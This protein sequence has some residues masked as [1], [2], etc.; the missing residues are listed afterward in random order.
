MTTGNPMVLLVDDDEFHLDMIYAQLLAIGYE[1]VVCAAS[2]AQ[3]LA[4]L[5]TW[6][7]AIGTVIC[8][9]SMP[10]MD[11]LVLIRHLAQRHLSAGIILLSGAQGE[12]L[13]SAARLV[14]AHKMNLLGVLAKPCSNAQLQQLLS[15][16]QPTSAPSRP[17]LAPELTAQ[18]LKLALASGEF[19]PWYQPKLDIRSG[20]VVGVEALAR[21]PCAAGGMIGP[22]RFV[23]AMEAAGLA[24]ALFF[25]M[26]RQ[27]AQDLSDW[28]RQHI[29]VKAALNLSMSTALN[30][31]VPEQLQCIVHK[32]GLQPSDFIIEVTESQLMVNRALIMESL[33]RLS[34]MGFVLS[35]DDFGTGYSSLVQ[36]ID[37]PFKE[38]KIDGSFVQ[39]AS[40]EQKAQSV[41][42]M[43]ILLGNN[44]AMQV[45]A[46]GVET[47]E[48]LEFVRLWGGHMVQGYHFA[49]PMPL[50]ECTAFLVQPRQL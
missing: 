34:L 49:R 16:L 38:L 30:L 48:Q 21:W 18:R 47:Q 25:A 26:A 23:P 24:D 14:S 8:D 22:A 43:A 9:L 31:A 5:E 32:A 27:V 41:L 6:G 1:R 35:I 45:V 19:I 29:F 28:Q 13:H 12:I 11:G 15:R 42:R 46:E 2:G 40:T 3:A 50:A 44:L 39:R 4:E 33:T 20:L 10:D 17:D 37:L 36:L 7:P